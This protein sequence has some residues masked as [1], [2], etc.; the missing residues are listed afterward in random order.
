MD[1][2]LNV[3]YQFNEKYVPYAGVSMTSLLV[4][5]KD[6]DAINI[7]VLGEGLSDESVGMIKGLVEWYDRNVFFPDTFPLLERFRDMGM[8]PYRGAYS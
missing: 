2:T 8:I 4:N 3:I 6:A 5:N 7:Y 1:K